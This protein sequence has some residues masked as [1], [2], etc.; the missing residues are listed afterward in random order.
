MGFFRRGLALSAFLLH[1]IPFAHG[2]GQSVKATGNTVSFQVNLTWEDSKPA[3]IPRKMILSNGQSPAPTLNLKQGDDVEF[4]VNND[5]PFSTT[6]HFHGIEQHNT[7]WSDGVPGLSQRPIP[8][9]GSFLYKWRATNYGIYFYHAHTRGQQEDGLY[10]AIHILPEDTLKKP[11]SLIS[12]NETE[13][14]AMVKAERKST[15]I[16]LSDVRALTAEELWEAEIAMGRDAV[17][18]NAL[19]VNGKGSVN[20]LG[21]E[22]LDQVT[23]AAM[24]GVLGNQSLTDIG[25]LP[26][27]NSI[28]QGTFA[29]NLSAI[30]PTVF[31]GC[32]PSQGL[33]ERLYA[34]ATKT[35]V[36]YDFISAAFVS[37]IT[38]SIDEHPMYVY[39]VDGEYI[40]P[41]LVDAI[42]ITNGARFSVLV[43]LDK[44][45]GDYTIR[46]ANSG[47]NQVLTGTA[48]LTYQN[49]GEPQQQLSE[50]SIDLVGALTSL[51][52]TLL[53]ESLVVPLQA[54]NVAHVPVAQTRVL[55]LGHYNASYTWTMGNAS[56]PLSLEEASPLLFFPKTGRENLTI[57]TQNG[58]W[59]DI[60]FDVTNPLQPP[61]PIHKH[62]NKFFVIGQGEG[63]WNYTSVA[64]AV[65]HIPESF[66]FETPQIRDSYATLPA[67]TGPTWLAIRYHVVNPGAFL[68]HCHIQIHQSGGMAIALLDGIDEWPEI[69]EEYQL[70][71]DK[72]ER[73]FHH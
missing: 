11:F 69:P 18:A 63:K 34:D 9:G 67:A 64:E 7:P 53:D 5:M 52:Y 21:Q 25:C 56:F 50:P 1:L 32:V 28:A 43:K 27:S 37:S 15:P 65:K 31:S 38:Y 48:L 3:G 14:E 16:F 71:E 51:N 33:T 35:Y 20:C 59:V 10:G 73:R 40:E 66:N 23:T 45:A 68:L 42:T 19:L 41:I 24:K 13:L 6:I 60:I 8:P 55:S 4:L 46:L 61:H 49:G 36:S 70:V 29:H 2:Y 57:A 62:S 22:T 72:L 47:V 30:P 54:H 12:D 26:P 44:P 39:A 17:C 58:T